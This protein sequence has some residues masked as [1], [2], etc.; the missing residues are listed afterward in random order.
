MQHPRVHLAVVFTAILV[1]PW[2]S[3]PALITVALAA[4]MWHLIQGMDALRALLRSLW[5]L[6]WLLLAIALV[7]LWLP[8]EGGRM[9]TLP[10]AT[11][12][13]TRMGE[14]LVR[15]SVVIVMLSVVHGLV[16][17]HPPRVLGAVL[18]GLLAPLDRVG[19]PGSRFGIRLA[20]LMAHVSAERERLARIREDA[21]RGFSPRRLPLLLAREVHRIESDA[22]LPAPEWPRVGPAPWHIRGLGLLLIIVLILLLAL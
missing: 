13:Q 7:Y 5:R 11:A 15:A 6:K 22:R 2:L 9:F 10:D 12:F 20:I 19:L 3:A 1:V 18:S 8:D 17:S 14:G 4:L 16:Y 21:G